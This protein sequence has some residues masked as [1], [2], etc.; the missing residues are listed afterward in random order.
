MAPVVKKEEGVKKEGV[1]DDDEKDGAKD[2]ADAEKEDE[3]ADAAPLVAKTGETC[4]SFC[5]KVG[6]G[7]ED[8]EKI[9]GELQALYV[10]LDEGKRAELDTLFAKVVDVTKAKGGSQEHKVQYYAPRLRSQGDKTKEKDY[11][12]LFLKA[13]K[14]VGRSKNVQ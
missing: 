1:M 11:F 14:Y 12:H 6:L 7:P 10:K 2:D 4:S 8:R 9:A 5:K 3:N 13:P